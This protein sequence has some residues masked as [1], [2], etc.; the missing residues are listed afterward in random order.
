MN[1]DWQ[2]RETGGSNRTLKICDLLIDFLAVRGDRKEVL[3]I[4]RGDGVQ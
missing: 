1:I 3:G 4:V 2:H